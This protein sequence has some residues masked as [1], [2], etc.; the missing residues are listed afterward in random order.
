MD[1]HDK[2][3]LGR[4]ANVVLAK[5]GLELRHTKD[6]SE[7]RAS[8][9]G[10][11][12]NA[13]RSNL[14]PN[15]IIDVGAAWGS[16]TRIAAQIFPGK[17]YLMVEPLAEYANSLRALIEEQ[18]GR[19]T[20][21]KA[22]A[23]AEPGTVTFNVH[24]DLVGSSLLRETEGAVT[25]G[26]PRT[27]STIRLDDEILSRGLSAPHVLKLDVQ[28]SELAVLDGA[29]RVLKD[30]ELA[31]LEVSFFDFFQGGSSM[32]EVI[33]YM[34]ERGFV[35]Y[36]ITTPLYRP[37]DGALAQLD[38]CFAQKSGALRRDH[39]YAT[40]EQR[41]EQNRVMAVALEKGAVQHH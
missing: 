28:G 3:M 4:L 23:A 7:G 9:A 29:R 34:A 8:H 16:F 17:D 12:E 30:T 40:P 6:L 14:N 39:I 33:S 31:I 18:D 41:R 24:D 11:L 19:A 32:V 5:Y 25:D 26:R 10:I 2:L 36:D 38:L 22:V 35:P 27:V 1:E 15:S 37:L 13:R 21:I 20:W